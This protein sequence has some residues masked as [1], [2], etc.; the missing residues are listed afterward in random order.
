MLLGCRVNNHEEH[1]GADAGADPPSRDGRVSSVGSATGAGDSDAG[2]GA[3]TGRLLG[4]GPISGVTYEAPSFAGVTEDDGRFH[5]AEG[6]A[7]TFRLGDTIF[8]T[9]VG[10][11]EVTLFDLVGIEPPVGHDAI[12]NAV[13]PPYWNGYYPPMW[14]LISIAIVLQTLD[15]DGDPLNGIEISAEVASLFDDVA[16][17]FSQNSSVFPQEP[18]FRKVFNAAK[19]HHLLDPDRPIMKRGRAMANLYQGLG[20]DSKLF[21][22]TGPGYMEDEDSVFVTVDWNSG[23]SMGDGVYE[24]SRYWE[25]DRIGNDVYHEWDS[26][27]DD[28]VINQV[29][30]REYDPNGDLSLEVN[31][32]D[33]SNWGVE[34]IS[35]SLR[36]YEYDEFGRVARKE[37]TS[38][39]GSTLSTYR[40]QYTHDRLTRREVDDDGDGEV[41]SFHEWNYENDL[42]TLS[43]GDTDADGTVDV[44]QRTTYDDRGRVLRTEYEEDGRILEERTWQYVDDRLDASYEKGPGRAESWKFYDEDGRLSRYDTRSETVTYVYEG[45]VRRAQGVDTSGARWSNVTEYNE[46]GLV[47][48]SE[49]DSDDDGNF[50][51]VTVYDFD[52]HGNPIRRRVDID[53]DGTFELDRTYHYAPTNHWECFFQSGQNASFFHRSC[54]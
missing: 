1:V 24:D 43:A 11:A 36:T 18:T 31:V 32:W 14:S 51:R 2:L 54:Y 34:G 28:D 38:R 6:D 19:R 41:D 45:R 37:Y 30:F 44:A 49:T 3:H 10:A 23:F 47:A 46:H 13:Y 48:R 7:I 25:Y 39:S 12:V 33:R 29:R 40:Y 5:Y 17:R 21:V 26:N 53:N 22:L 8:G 42:L 35:I 27:R 50:D 16:V 9:V 52:Q 15:Y 20:I 4:S